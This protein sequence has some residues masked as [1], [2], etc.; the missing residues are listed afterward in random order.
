MSGGRSRR[1]TAG[2]SQMLFGFLLLITTPPLLHTHLPP[3]PE[4]CDSPEQAAHYHFQVRPPFIMSQ[5][6]VKN[7]K[8][9]A[10]CSWSSVSQL[11]WMF[12]VRISP[13][14]H[15]VI[16]FEVFPL[17]SS[18]L[19]INFVNMKAFIKQESADKRNRPDQVIRLLLSNPVA[20]N[21]MT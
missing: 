13:R 18:V 11:V 9:Y 15:A 3:P 8:R 14:R 4:A 12:L 16:L 1:I 6:K 7:Y 10:E 19:P 2:F 20:S 5:E 17:F 21:C